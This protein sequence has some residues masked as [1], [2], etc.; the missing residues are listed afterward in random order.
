M[1]VD[2]TKVVYFLLSTL[3]SSIDIPK[4]SAIIELK[5]AKSLYAYPMCNLS[6]TDYFKEKRLKL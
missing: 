6:I 2:P 4:A 3:R 1:V 5:T